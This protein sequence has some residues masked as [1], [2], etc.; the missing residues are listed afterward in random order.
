M[1]EW[2]VLTH[3]VKAVSEHYKTEILKNALLPVK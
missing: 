2:W 1:C 3:P